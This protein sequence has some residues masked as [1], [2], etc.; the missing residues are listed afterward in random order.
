[1]KRIHRAIPLCLALFAAASL[2]AGGEQEG[3]LGNWVSGSGFVRTETRD[4]PSFT[5]VEVDGAGN[6][7]LS[8]GLVQSVTVETDDNVLPFITTEVIG[9][10]LHLGTRHDTRL[11]NVRRLEFRISAPSIEGILIAGSGNV[12]SITPLRA[13]RMSLEI[14]GS[15]S[16]DTEVRTA[17][18]TTRIGGSGGISAR[19]RATDL[20]VDIGGSGSVDAR[21][22]T[23][24]AARVKISG[25]GGAS[26]YV[27]NT[28]DVVIS[29]SGS[30]LYSGGA[31]ITVRSSGSGSVTRL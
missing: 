12:R 14:R 25:S 24:A 10:V 18:L 2:F 27:D 23:A 1:M 6:V 19:G 31:S 16:I 9:G 3:L 22:L 28:L 15:G 4:V 5:A 26:V 11:T 29:G 21:G 17:S 13:D 20:S 7:T 30:V 8:Q